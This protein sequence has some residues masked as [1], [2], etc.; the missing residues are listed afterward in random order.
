MNIARSLKATLAASVCLLPLQALAQSNDA[1]GGVGK[2]AAASQ[3]EPADNWISIG[4]QYRSDRS[5]YLGRFSGAVDRGFYGLGDFQFRGRDAWDSGGTWYWEAIG[6]DLGFTDRSFSAKVGNQGTWGATLSYDGIPY[7]G[8]DSFKSVWTRYGTLV[9]G[10]APGGLA[11]TFSQLAP[12][13]GAFLPVWIPVAT[14][15]P[16]ALLFNYRIGTQ[17]DVFAGTGKYQWNDWTI[18]GAV[19]HEHKTGYVGNSATIGGVPSITT[20]SA[21]APT[22]FTSGLG[23]FAQPIDYD[24]DRYDVTAAYGNERLQAQVGYTF[25]NFTDNLAILNLQNPFKFFSPTLASTFGAGV[26]PGSLFAPYVLPPSTSAHQVKLML[27]YNF[28][29]TMRLNVNFAYGLQ[30]QNAGF[31]TATGDPVSNP[32]QP[33]SSFDGLVRTLHGNVALTAQPLPKLD[34]RIAYTIDDRANQSPRNTYLVNPVDAAGLS[35]L[36]NVPF[37]YDHQTVTADIGY[38]ILPHTKV[39]LNDTYETT[40]R[41]YSNVSYVTSNTVTAKV[42]SQVLDDVF[43]ALSYSHQDRSARNYNPVTSPNSIPATFQFLGITGQFDQAGLLVAY[44]APRKR[45]EVKATVDLA[46]FGNVSASLIAK[47]ANDTY[48]ESTY[49][50]RNNRNI[51]VGPDVNW[52]AT[53]ALNFHAYYTYQQLFRQQDSLYTNTNN[54]A[55]PPASTSAGLIVP[56]TAKTTDS[57]H[58]F[59]LNVDWQ[60]IKDVLKFSLDYNFAYGDTAY[61]LGDSVVLFGTGINSQIT[62]QAV[63]IQPVPDITSMLNMVSIRGEYTFRPNVTLIFG[64][65]LEKFTYKDFM[66]GVSATTFANGL[67]PGTVNPNDTVHVVGAGMHIRF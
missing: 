60:A 20:S 30:M 58:T 49:G 37:S 21:A 50:L 33:R 17:R 24:T 63:R 29:P 23:Y 10:V 52:Q 44:M 46:A 35:S 65:A 6:R 4:A 45:D 12:A 53:P 36:S 57:V 61:A 42:R 31:Q 38:R 55:T 16:A 15:S 25:S 27:G 22:S 43:G 28:T 66:Y 26:G 67:L 47:F 39:S 13:S 32:T 5:F 56:W 62:Q 40:Y 19:R 48:P 11:V 14:N 18:T 34:M 59:G 64:Y 1:Y 3:S 7:N 9:P 8:T 51:T 54:P 41:N 2:P